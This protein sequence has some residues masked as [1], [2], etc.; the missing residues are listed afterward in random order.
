MAWVEKLPGKPVRWRGVWR[1]PE[2]KKRCTTKKT[3]PLHPY[4][5]KGDALHAAAEAEARGRR[6]AAAGAGT[7]AA[8]I[9]WGE[10][11]DQSRPERPHSDTGRNEHYIVE[12]YLRP[13]WGDTPLNRIRQRP[14]QM[15]VS[16]ELAPGRAPNYARRIY[17]VF[18]ASMSR[19]V[20]AEVLDASPCVKIRLPKTKRTVKPFV[21]SEHLTALA[22]A[23]EAGRLYLP[24]A[25]HRD[26]IEV[27]YET[28][29]RPGE[30]SGLHA[31]QLDLDGGWLDVTNVFVK[32]RGVI[33]GWPKDE[34]TRRVPLTVRAV[35]ILRRHVG[36]RVDVGCGV[37]HVDNRPC[38]GRLVFLS[39]TRG[40]VTQSALYKSMQRAAQRAGIDHRSPYALRRGF[41]TWAASGLDAYALAE[42]MGHADLEETAGYVQQT[43]AAR[44]RLR[45]ARGESVG[46]S[47]VEGDGGVTHTGDEK[48]GKA[49]GG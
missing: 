29:L 13:K 3:H 1:T 49:A 16:D 25:V 35:E 44:D 23:D 12:R 17:G 6:T 46:L 30:L 45:A 40:P 14:V 26:L 33:R 15:W 42:I 41:A 5:L 9:T 8:K 38:R 37:P 4:R 20:E 32:H 27:G 28:G 2:G 22:G 21:D 19:A 18:Q 39:A 31:D 36:G 24:N 34:D 48:Q 47:V 10:W 7:L 11:W 43:A